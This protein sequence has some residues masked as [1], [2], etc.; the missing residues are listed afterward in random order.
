M[1][2]VNLF[3]LRATHPKELYADP[4]PISHP[5]QP[6]RC[7]REILKTAWSADFVICAWGT[8]GNYMNRAEEILRQL[9]QYGVTPHALRI[10]TDGSPAHPLRISYNTQLVTI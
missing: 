4:A 10:N 1:D 3:A 2:I 8:H 9:K 6:G 7:T 5:E